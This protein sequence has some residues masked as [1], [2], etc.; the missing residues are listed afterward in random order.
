MYGPL[1]LVPILAL[2]DEAS[3]VTLLDAEVVKTPWLT[4]TEESLCLQLANE[5]ILIQEDTLRSDVKV[6]KI[7]NSKIFRMTNV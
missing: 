1:G 2:C 6:S 3:T 4:G 7:D 5:N